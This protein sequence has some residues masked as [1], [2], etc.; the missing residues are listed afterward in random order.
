MQEIRRKPGIGQQPRFREMEEE[1]ITHFREGT[2]IVPVQTADKENGEKESKVPFM[3]MKNGDVYQP[4][5]TDMPEFFKFC[6][7][8]QFRAAVI[9]YAKLNSVILKQAKGVIMN[10]F[11]V[12]LIL[13][14]G[15]F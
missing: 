12:R 10:P 7:D 3:K 11:G 15:Q 8:G 14:K 5:F 13:N 1:M 9:P 2:F 4:I 6:R